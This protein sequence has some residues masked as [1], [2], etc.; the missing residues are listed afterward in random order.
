MVNRQKIYTVNP[1]KNLIPGLRIL[2]LFQDH[3]SQVYRLRCF[4]KW[5]RKTKAAD[6]LAGWLAG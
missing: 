2:V 5:P 6:W 1:A 3:F 4:G